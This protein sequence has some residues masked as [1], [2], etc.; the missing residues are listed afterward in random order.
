VN[1]DDASPYSISLSSYSLNLTFSISGE[2]T[3]VYMSQEEGRRHDKL[4]NLDEY[5]SKAR[6][7]KYR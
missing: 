3:Q 5:L 2:K 4:A 6:T 7:E 1:G